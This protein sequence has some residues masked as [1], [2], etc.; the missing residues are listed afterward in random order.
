MGA[1]LSF[2]VGEVWYCL[3]YAVAAFFT[4][5]WWVCAYVVYGVWSAWD[6]VVARPL[7][8]ARRRHGTSG[9][10]SE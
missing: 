2:L 10:S 3:D 9:G 7:A 6:V 1:W 8:A 4:M 5:V